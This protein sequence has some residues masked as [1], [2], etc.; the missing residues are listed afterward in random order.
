MSTDYRSYLISKAPHNFSPPPPGFPILSLAGSE[1]LSSR[2]QA[3]S[4]RQQGR[5]RRS[6]DPKGWGAGWAWR[7]SRAW[8]GRESRWGRGRGARGRPRGEHRG[9][10]RS[11]RDLQRKRR[12]ITVT[13]S[14]NHII[15]VCPIKY[16][17]LC[18]QNKIEV[19]K[20]A[21]IR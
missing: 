6:C 13:I 4:G 8:W 10:G 9:S 18:L 17:T 14:D 19:W 1:L 5:A 2:R 16:Q 15:H 11:Q 12:A 20:S 21:P 7:W 3:G